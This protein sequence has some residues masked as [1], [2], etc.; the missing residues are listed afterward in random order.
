MIRKDW[1]QPGCY[2]IKWNQD[3]IYVP[4]SGKIIIF[5]YHTC[6]NYTEKFI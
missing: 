5:L 6:E 1:S 3:V 4:L 2:E